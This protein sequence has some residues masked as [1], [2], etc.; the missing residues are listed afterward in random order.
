V[1]HTVGIGE[2]WHI[3]LTICFL[4]NVNIPVQIDIFCDAVTGVNTNHAECSHMQIMYSVIIVKILSA[5]IFCASSLIIFMK[6]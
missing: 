1:S 2:N 3:D 6:A 4:R 5:S